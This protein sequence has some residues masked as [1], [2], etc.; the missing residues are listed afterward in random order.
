MKGAVKIIGVVDRMIELV[1]SRVPSEEGVICRDRNDAL[2][3]AAY[4]RCWRC[5]R[6]IRLLAERENADDAYILA[7]SLAETTLRALWLAAPTDPTEREQR[8][9]RLARAWFH[10]Q[11]T[12]AEKQIGFG[13]DVDVEPERLRENVDMLIA[14]GVPG[15]PVLETIADEVG[16]PEV[17]ARICRPTSHVVHY[18]LGAALDGFIDL[19]SAMG[20]GVALELPQLEGAEE[21]LT[22]AAITYGAF[23][24]KCESVIRHGVTEDVKR[25]LTEHFDEYASDTSAS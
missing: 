20:G 3:V 9:Q 19:P 10:E 21:A 16:L 1:A 7:R 14:S 5:L 17:Y 22:L 15:A 25:M 23:L 4:G 6:A 2:L 18:S 12:H 24:E 11:A 8:F 13:F